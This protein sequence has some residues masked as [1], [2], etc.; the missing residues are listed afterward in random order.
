MVKDRGNKMPG[1]FID[2][3]DAVT[4]EAVHRRPDHY[5][6]DKA[7]REKKRLSYPNEAVYQKRYQWWLDHGYGPL[8]AKW[9][10]SHRFG[11]P[12]KTR[13]LEKGDASS[14][15]L[16]ISIGERRPQAIA[17][18]MERFHLTEDEAIEKLDKELRIKNKKQQDEDGLLFGN[19]SI[20][21]KRF[22]SNI[23]KDISP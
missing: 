7:K 10:A 9:A 23:F 11:K 22:Q 16:A 18:Q 5:A 3:T 13:G 20:W 19:E 15:A 4:P 14:I 17:S 8:P 21:D 12:E 2:M 6:S 1:M